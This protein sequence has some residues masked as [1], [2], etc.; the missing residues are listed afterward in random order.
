[1]REANEFDLFVGRRIRELR[2]AKGFS[3]KDLAKRI[4]ISSQQLQKYENWT[5]RICAGRLY[6]IAKQLGVSVQECFPVPETIGAAPQQTG[7]IERESLR[8]LSD[9]LSMRLHQ[10]FRCIVDVAAK[11]E[12]IEIAEKSARASRAPERRSRR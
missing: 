4:G 6:E 12:I 11:I 5:D 7:E 10:A 9:P 8:V 3:Q 2:K 1:M